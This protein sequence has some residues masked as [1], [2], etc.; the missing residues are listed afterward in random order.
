M[1][2]RFACSNLLDKFCSDRCGKR[3]ANIRR[4]ARK[5][6]NTPQPRA[7]IRKHRIH[8]RDG[9]TC[10]LC[11]DPI[12]QAVKVPHPLAATLDHVIPLAKGGAHSEANLQTA[13]FLCN[14]RKGDRVLEPLTISGS[15]DDGEPAGQAA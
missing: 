1:V 15:S 2:D 10:Q 13:H 9:W 14:S 11:G 7:S 5:R 8:V 4:S 12:D 3:S 6:S